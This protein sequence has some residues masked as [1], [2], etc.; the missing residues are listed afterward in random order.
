MYR[1]RNANDAKVR[2]E[3]EVK[4]RDKESDRDIGTEVHT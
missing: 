4:T 1:R 3:K 2:Y